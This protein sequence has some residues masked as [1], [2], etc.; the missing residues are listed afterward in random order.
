MEI[1]ILKEKIEK[2]ITKIKK[3]DKDYVIIGVIVIAVIIFMIIN[4]GKIK[5]FENKDNDKM[6]NVESSI[7]TDN[8]K[9]EE[10]KEQKDDNSKEQIVNGGGIFVHIDGYINNPG[11]YEIKENDRIKTLIDKAGGFKEGY[12][13]KNINLAAKLSDGDKIYI[14]SVSEEK[15]SEDNNNNN[16]NSSGKGQN[17]KNDRNNVSVMKNNSKININTANISELK[18]I[19]GIGESTANKIIDYRENVG[20]FKKI[21]DIKEVKGI[22]DAKYESLKNKI[23]I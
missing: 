7:N 11:V 23:T 21:E 13:I 10:N 2:I 6:T 4:L 12:S 9:S 3:I 5:E 16:T 14:P 15:V 17:V 8:D 20:K 22:G 19:T 1:N 18:Q